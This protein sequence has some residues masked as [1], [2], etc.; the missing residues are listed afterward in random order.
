MLK[1]LD[2][3]DAWMNPGLSL[4]GFVQL[5]VARFERRGWLF[6]HEA[7]KLLPLLDLI[8]KKP[9]LWFNIWVNLEES[10]RR[11]FDEHPEGRG[12]RLLGALGV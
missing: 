3:D 11:I 8:P 6:D 9:V 7:Y 5:I 1:E 2:P 4:K 10:E 12:I